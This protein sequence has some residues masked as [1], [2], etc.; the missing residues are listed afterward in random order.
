MSPVLRIAALSH[1]N[2]DKTT[3]D[4]TTTKACSIGKYD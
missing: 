3:D 4:G 1:D 2:K